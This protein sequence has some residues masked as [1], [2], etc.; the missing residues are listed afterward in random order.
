MVQEMTV[1]ALV[2]LL[3]REIEERRTLVAA[4]R[5][6][7]GGEPKAA[8]AARRTGVGAAVVAI[9]R[10]AGR[11]MHGLGE[12]LPALNARGF[13]VS[14]RAGFASVV[15]RTGQT[16]RTAPGTYALKSARDVVAG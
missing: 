15:L 1:Q 11:P 3:E 7:M 5:A 8:P 2:C 9:L 12:I 13:E 10:E 16:V 14:R 6:R 4:L